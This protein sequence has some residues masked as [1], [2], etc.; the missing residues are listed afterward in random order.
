MDNMIHTPDAVTLRFFGF[1]PPSPLL[2]P[3]RS[4][5]PSPLSAPAAAVRAAASA[6]AFSAAFSAAD[7]FSASRKLHHWHDVERNGV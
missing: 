2:S 1:G 7:A 3:L 4:A 5:L 6:A